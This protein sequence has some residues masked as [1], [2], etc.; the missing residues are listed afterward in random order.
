MASTPYTVA[1]VMTPEVV[2]VTL[3]ATGRLPTG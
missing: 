2:A 1:D 3:R